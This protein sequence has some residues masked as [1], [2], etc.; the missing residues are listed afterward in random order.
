MNILTTCS[1][2]NWSLCCAY[3]HDSDRS[4]CDCRPVDRANKD[5]SSDEWT[6]FVDHAIYDVYDVNKWPCKRFINTSL[7][8]MVILII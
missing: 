8:K 2:S 1:S 6:H 3:L 5:T 4:I 7:K